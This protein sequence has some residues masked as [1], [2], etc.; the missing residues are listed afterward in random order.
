MID[1][2]TENEPQS[3]FKEIVVNF[4]ENG[5]PETPLVALLEENP[6]DI[7][8]IQDNHFDSRIRH[9]MVYPDT[10]QIKDLGFTHYLIE[11]PETSQK[12]LDKLD[13][14]KTVDL[15]N[16][17]GL[18]PQSFK[19]RSFADAIYAMNGGGL[20]VVAIDHPD[21]TKKVS[22]DTEEREKKLTDNVL[23]ILQE[24]GK[25]TVLIGAL[26]ALL[27]SSEGVPSVAQRLVDNKIRVVSIRYFSSKPSDTD[28]SRTQNFRHW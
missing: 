28:S 15:F 17:S 4:K 23:K 12:L 14:G 7:V 18:G 25:P 13:T 21:I 22:L 8:F 9:T 11:A 16:T 10:K 1:K 20:K 2:D 26:H 27:R 3:S 24:G 5:M 6:A 19:D